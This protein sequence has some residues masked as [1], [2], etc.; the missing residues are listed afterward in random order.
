MIPPTELDCYIVQVPGGFEQAACDEFERMGIA[1]FAP[2]LRR[3][4]SADPRRRSRR[5]VARW[6][7][8]MAGYV[9]VGF[10][11]GFEN[12]GAVLELDWVQRLLF[13]A[14]PDSLVRVPYRLPRSWHIGFGHDELRRPRHVD[15]GEA[16]PAYGENDHVMITHEAFDRFAAKCVSID[17]ASD[18]ATVLLDFFGATREVKIR[19]DDA[20]KLPARE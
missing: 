17:E 10:R 9:F 7:T 11:P 4:V 1:A 2:V 8:V 14:H 18:T 5:Q 6:D 20:V 3:W 15:A 12:F 16:P 13:L 19:R